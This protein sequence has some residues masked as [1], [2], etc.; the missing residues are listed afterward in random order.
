VAALTGV[1]AL[2]LLAGCGPKPVEAF[3]PAPSESG[4]AAYWVEGY[5]RPGQL[6]REFAEGYADSFARQVCP[7]AFTVRR[8]DM[9]PVQ[10]AFDRFLY[11]QALVEC[12]DGVTPAGPMRD[13]PAAPAP[14]PTRDRPAAA[15]APPPSPP[16]AAPAAPGGTEGAPLDL[17]PGRPAAPAP[18]APADGTPLPLTPPS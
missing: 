4:L 14:A 11:W 12:A 2:A 5:T 7:G 10:N 18:G 15:P 13:G 17:S 6:T 16:P 3:G 8:V 9:R 1:A